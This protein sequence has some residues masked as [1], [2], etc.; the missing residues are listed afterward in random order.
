MGRLQ[1]KK[2]ESQ[3]VK[4]KKKADSLVTESKETVSDNK[5][6]SFTPQAKDANNKS[7]L[8]PKKTG[9]P[10]PGT[11]SGEQEDNNIARL[12]QYLRE[13]K[14][15]LKKV[16][17]PARKQIMASTVVVII[18]V[19]ILSLFL[20]VVDTGLSNLVKLVL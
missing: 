13:V 2:T 5:V 7:V 1:R 14:V 10:K 8:S 20:G 18:L 19:V 16:T 3:K 12:T 11:P 6:V 4:K 17:W 9:S 15:E